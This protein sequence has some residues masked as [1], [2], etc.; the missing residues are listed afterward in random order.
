[1]W[2]ASYGSQDDLEQAQLVWFLGFEAKLMLARLKL[3]LSEL[4]KLHRLPI[5]RVRGRA[6]A[7]IAGLHD[8]IP[9]LAAAVAHGHFKRR[10]RVQ[11][12]GPG[13]EII[14]GREAHRIV[15]ARFA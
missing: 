15:P 9:A 13:H 14:G 3:E 1:M 10:R 4:H 7:L 11:A 2:L 8:K 12:D 5:T 6:H